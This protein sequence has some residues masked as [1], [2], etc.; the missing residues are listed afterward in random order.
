MIDTHANLTTPVHESAFDT[1]LPDADDP[2]QAELDRLTASLDDLD[3]LSRTR[4]LVAY[5]GL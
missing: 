1:A 4:G 2:A 5:C 3:Y